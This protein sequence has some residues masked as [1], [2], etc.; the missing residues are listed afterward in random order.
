MRTGLRILTAITCLL[1]LAALAQEGW[2]PVERIETYPVTGKS[3]IALY[4]SIGENGPKVGIGRAIAYTDYK[5]TW[6]RDYRPQAGG[7]VLAAA[8]PNLLITYRLPQPSNDLPPATRRLWQT[9]IEGVEKH[10]RV[11]GD[12]ILDVVKKIEAVSV[13]LTVAD[14][15]DCTKTR[16]ELQRRLVPLAAELKQ[17]SREFDRVEMSEGGNVHRLVLGLVNGGFPPA[18]MGEAAPAK[19]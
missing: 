3:G 14:D 7:C 5:L 15:P 11:H 16:A 9:F 12:I 13:G 18:A 8:T 17:R 6:R 4:E 2:A 10:E 19:P 1:P